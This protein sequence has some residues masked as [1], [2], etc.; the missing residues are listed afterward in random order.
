MITLNDIIAK[1][2]STFFIKVRPVDSIRQFSHR[3]NDLENYIMDAIVPKYR[4]KVIG[5]EKDIYGGSS[6]RPVFDDE[7]QREWD[8]ELHDYISRKAEWCRKY[9]SN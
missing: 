8:K 6:Y 4:N 3:I 1:E 2:K 7:T 9:G 5:F